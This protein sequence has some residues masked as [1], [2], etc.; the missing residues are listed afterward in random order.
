MSTLFCDDNGIYWYSPDNWNHAPSG[1][2]A[3]RCRWQYLGNNGYAVRQEHHDLRR[4]I[5]T[6]FGDMVPTWPGEW[7]QI[8]EVRP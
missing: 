5:F 2:R 1:H 7:S 4:E 3:Q 8:D 6:R